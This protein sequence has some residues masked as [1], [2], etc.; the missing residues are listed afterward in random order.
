MEITHV[1]V[2]SISGSVPLCKQSQCSMGENSDRHQQTV[3]LNSLA[4]GLGMGILAPAV[5]A[6]AVVL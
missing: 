5:I 1:I 4:I 6:A 2:M 3:Q